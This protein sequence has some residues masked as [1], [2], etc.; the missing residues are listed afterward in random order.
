[1][2]SIVATSLALGTAKH[3]LVWSHIIAMAYATQEAPWLRVEG[4]S[5]NLSC[6]TISTFFK[7]SEQAFCHKPNILQ[8]HQTTAVKG[9]LAKVALLT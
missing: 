1:M 3:R 6:N 9:R 8:Q 7:S 2:S 4:E 5:D